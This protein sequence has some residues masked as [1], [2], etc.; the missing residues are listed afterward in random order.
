MLLNAIENELLEFRVQ[1][2]KVQENRP[3]KNLTNRMAFGDGINFVIST[4]TTKE[5]RSLK[6]YHRLINNGTIDE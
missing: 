5:I 3:C 1:M 6:V 2:V 4:L